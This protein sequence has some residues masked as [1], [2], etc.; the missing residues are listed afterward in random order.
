M[1]LDY[2]YRSAGTLGG[3]HGMDL[4][5]RWQPVVKK[6]APPPKKKTPPRRMTLKKKR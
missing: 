1:D 2:A 4:T 3:I 5:W 6:K